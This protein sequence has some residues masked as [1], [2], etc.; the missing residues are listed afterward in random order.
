MARELASRGIRVNAVA[1][2]FIQTDMTDS[3]SAKLKEQVKKQIPMGRMGDPGGIA[4][5]VGFLSSDQAIY[6]T[7]PVSYTHLDVYKRQDQDHD[8]CVRL[9]LF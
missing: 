1:P 5:V 3:L 8:Q 6:I 2:G 7:G 4:S 9:W